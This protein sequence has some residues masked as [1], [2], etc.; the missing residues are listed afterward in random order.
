MNRNQTKMDELLNALSPINVGRVAGAGNK[1]VYMLDE[2][3]D[4]ERLGV[5]IST[6]STLV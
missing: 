1:I 3:A 4:S 6:P 5:R 2:L